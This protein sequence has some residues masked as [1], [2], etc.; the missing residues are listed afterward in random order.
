ME[1]NK[2]TIDEICYIYNIRNELA[3]NRDRLRH[4]L[5]YLQAIKRSIQVRDNPNLDEP[6][7]YRKEYLA[8]YPI[9]KSRKSTTLKDINAEVLK[10]EGDLCYA[11]VAIMKHTKRYSKKTK[12]LAKKV[13]YSPKYVCGVVVSI[14]IYSKHDEQGTPMN[15][16]FIGKKEMK[17]RADQFNLN[18]AIDKMLGA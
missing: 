11:K 10:M 1:D 15:V 4:K 14:N 3:A 12:E 18:K 5:R 16:V 2:T 13:H 7:S 9:P 6:L 17:S 8:K